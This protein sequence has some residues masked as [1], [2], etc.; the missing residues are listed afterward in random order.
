MQPDFTVKRRAILIVLGVLIAAD[1]GLAG[2]SYELAAAPHTP[3]KEFDAQ[4][5][6][7]KVLKED[8]KS[9]E[10]IKEE[11]PATK[12]DCDKFEQSLPLGNTG[13]SSMTADLD[14]VAKKA[15]LQIVTMAVKEKDLSARNVT[16]VEMDLTVNGDYGSVA[17]FVNGLQRSEKFYIVDGLTLSAENQKQSGGNGPLRVS[18]HLRTYFR[19]AA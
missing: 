2:Y 1:L 6:R 12:K 18:L 7:L 8:I 16:E 11:T 3:Q 15:G 14:E 9:A 13:S 19:G 10:T 17:R 5:L 4:N